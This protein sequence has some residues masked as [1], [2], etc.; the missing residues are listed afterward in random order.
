MDRLTLLRAP[1]SPDPTADR[2]EHEFEIAVIPH[3]GFLEDSHVHQTALEFCNPVYSKS[4]CESELTLVRSGRE[5]SKAIP[6][7]SVQNH[8]GGK[9]VLETIKLAEDSTDIILRIYETFGGRS[10]GSLVV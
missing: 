6:R 1:M 9:I 10:R 4:T 7:F 2:G 3:K 8:S 5:S